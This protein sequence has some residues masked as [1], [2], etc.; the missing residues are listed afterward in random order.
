MRPGP[1]HR[2]RRAV[3]LLAAALLLT[4]AP[5]TNAQ[6]PSC[7]WGDGVLIPGTEV[8]RLALASD[9]GAGLLVV[10]CPENWFDAPASKVGT[11]RLH[12]VLEQGRLDP[13][14]PEQGVTFYT[15]PEP[16]AYPGTDLARV[17]ADGSG[18][19]YVLM[20]SCNPTLAHLRCYEVSTL[21]LL[22][23]SGTG[24]T[25]PGW[26]DSGLVIASRGVPYALDSGDIVPDGAG[27]VIAAWIRSAPDSYLTTSVRA[28][29]WSA[30]GVALWPGGE[31]GLEL[32]GSAPERNNIRL[33]GDGAGGA[34]FALSALTATGRYDAFAVRV[35][36]D[37]S[38]PWG[39]S[40]AVVLSQTGYSSSVQDV[41][42]DANGRLFTAVLQTSIADGSNRLVTQLLTPAGARFWGTSGRVI[43]A[44]ASRPVDALLLGNDYVTA[45]FNPSLANF[46]ELQDVSGAPQWGPPDGLP[47]DWSNGA[48]LTSLAMPDGN[49]VCLWADPGSSYL[50]PPTVVHAIELEPSGE[51]APGWPPAS[52]VEV[53]GGLYALTLSDAIT[54]GG[55]IFVAFGNDYFPGP[56]PRVQRLSRAVLAVPPSPSM[57]AI[58]LSPPAPNPARGP[59]NVRFA[60]REPA[61]VALEAFDIAGRQVLQ[62]DLGTFTPGAHVVSADDGTSLAPGVY[63]VRVRAAGLTAER[64]LV[65]LH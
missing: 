60:L 64:M 16:N 30:T 8:R 11:L 3:R 4:C 2:S 51:I 59:W 43:G 12:H 57:N 1:E 25:S 21:R 40:G 48:P 33:A 26:P 55:Q 52:G 63:R 49:L 46:L 7:A 32:L 29:R 28:Q 56:T 37:G 44:A 35:L 42:M 54:V 47:A 9:G 65:R 36:A 34:T 15:P 5:K 50:G 20:R 45:H 6:A 38:L 31:A 18:G 13:S 62:R 10:S 53:C 17:L 22:H 27:G 39:T 58:E 61:S 14:L 19:A 24:T 41:A 23:V